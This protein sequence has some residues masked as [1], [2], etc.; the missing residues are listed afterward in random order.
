MEQTSTRAAAGRS[1]QRLICAL[2]EAQEREL[3]SKAWTRRLVM[4]EITGLSGRDRSS[5]TDF[6]R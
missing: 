5:R 4:R 6:S 2:P 1:A 3:L